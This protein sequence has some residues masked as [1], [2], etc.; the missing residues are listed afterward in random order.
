MPALLISPGGGYQILAMNLEGTEIASWAKS[1][2]FTPV[3]LKYRV[4]KQRKA[5]FADIQRAMSILR[6]NAK[7][8]N[9]IPDKIGII[10]FSAGG[11]LSARLSTHYKKRI[12]KPVDQ[13]DKVSMKPDFCILIYPA[14]LVDKQDH[15]KKD[16]KIVDQP[17]PTFLTQ[18]QDDPI[19]YRNSFFFFNTLTQHHVPAELH[20]FAKGG[21]GYGLR[22]NKSNPLSN[23]PNLCEKWLRS[24]HVIR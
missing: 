1:I 20:M 13:N 19:G 2:G 21:H 6:T 16:V 15:L 4:P 8:W 3:I 11:N 24:I 18:T 22:T 9:I 10:G 23:W 12:Y 5:A 17:P 7:K 14:Y